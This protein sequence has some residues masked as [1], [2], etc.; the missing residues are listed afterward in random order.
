MTVR[1]PGT[2]VTVTG[3]GNPLPIGQMVDGT[4][5]LN[6]LEG[7]K[8]TSAAHTLTL[9]PT[10]T[11]NLDGGSLELSGISDQGG[12]FNYLGGSLSM[13]S[14]FTLGF[15]GLL[16][17]DSLTLD[18]NDALATANTATIDPLCKLTLDGGTFSA[19]E[20]VNN[21]T[22]QFNSGTLRI[23]LDGL[24]I[25]AGGPLG[26]TVTFGNGQRFEVTNTLTVDSGATLVVGTGGEVDAG[27]LANSGNVVLDGAAAVLGGTSVSNSGVLRGEGVISANVTNNAGGEIRA[28]AGKTL[29]F[30]GANGANAGLVS[31][32]GGTA[33][34]AQALTNGAAG[35]ITGRGT[36]IVV[37]AGLTNL[38]HVALSSGITDVYG[39]VTNNTGNAAVGITVSGNA[40]VTFWDDVTNT[41]GLFRVSAGSS[42]T[43]FGG[44][45]GAGI[46][47]PGDVYLEADI[48]PGSSP[49]LAEF[50][51]NIH[52]GP[53]ANLEIE[54]AGT[55]RGDEYDALNIAGMALLDGSLDV[56][57]LSGFMPAVGDS[58]EIIDI[59]GARSGTFAGL[60]E[61]AAIGNF[62]G[63]DLL[64]TY[65]G[66]DGNDVALFVPGLPGD[67]NFDGSVDAA[68]YVVWRKNNGTLE[69]F[70]IWRANFGNTGGSG[71]GALVAGTAAVP[72]PATLLFAPAI[73]IAIANCRRN[74]A[75][76]R[77]TRPLNGTGD[78]NGG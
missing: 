58:F 75:F 35:Q 36:L 73:L 61:G 49:G 34:F 22:L 9:F 51:G 77:A 24:T 67:F 68:D 78:R 23:T 70:N 3:V 62:G 59:T 50:G 39:D 57:V 1:D 13:T 25:G 65:A 52:L 33:E 21:G 5:T 8:F 76:V 55:N 11:I 43:F 63:H 71:S 4:A 66:G 29:T 18:S 53:L 28:Q 46:S 64:I 2:T 48:T 74:T 41:S 72:E 42:A 44:F 17:T 45:A 7:G 31:L 10:G 26:N 20:L 69:K 47:G 56:S 32:Q 54:I 14:D 6:V 37:G 30:T 12:T 16:H 15:D 40:D 60:A 19:G 27:T 38:G